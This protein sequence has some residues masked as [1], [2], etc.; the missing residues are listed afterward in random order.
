MSTRQ[1]ASQAGKIRNDNK[2]LFRI[3]TGI[4]HMRKQGTDEMIILKRVSRKY[5]AKLCVL[6]LRSKVQFL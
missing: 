5:N 1:H 6:G 2:I 4:E 3:M